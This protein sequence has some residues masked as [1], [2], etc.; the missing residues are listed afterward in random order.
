MVEGSSP[1]GDGTAGRPLEAL[2][3]A[4]AQER[5]EELS[6]VDPEVMQYHAEGR[7]PEFFADLPTF[8]LQHV[9]CPVLLVQGNPALGAISRRSR[10]MRSL[11]S[12]TAPAATLGLR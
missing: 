2:L 5:A 4:V 8:E 1:S 9:P 7:L 10:T 6:R 12:T 3:P 11:Y